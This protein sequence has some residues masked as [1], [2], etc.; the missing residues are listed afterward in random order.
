MHESKGQHICKAPSLHLFHT[1]VRQ[2]VSELLGS[3]LIVT[4][5]ANIPSYTDTNAGS[6]SSFPGLVGG[7]KK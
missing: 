3:Y 6:Y 7:A 4:Y 5:E 2:R 1:A